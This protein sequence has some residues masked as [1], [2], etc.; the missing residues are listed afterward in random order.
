MTFE[1]VALHHLDNLDAKLANLRQVIAEDA[2][3]GSKWTSYNAQLG[4]KV[5]KG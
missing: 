5:Y 2:N 4:R 1:A 3:A